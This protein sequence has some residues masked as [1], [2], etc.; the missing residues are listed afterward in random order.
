MKTFCA[1]TLLA[2]SVWGA[3]TPALAQS[4][5]VDRR[6]IMTF[7]NKVELPGVTLDAGRYIF[8]LADPTSGRKVIQVL[9]ADDEKKVYGMFLSIP[10]DMDEAPDRATVRFM[11]NAAGTPAPIRAFWWAGT[12]TG[13]EFIYP[14]EQAMRIARAAAQPVLTTATNTTRVDQTNSDDLARISSAGQVTPGSGSAPAP[15]AQNSANRTMP[16]AS[17]S[18]AA[19]Q[20]TSG[21]SRAPE[22]TLARAEPRT[23][24]PATASG[25]PTMLAWG[26]TLFAAA[27]MLRVWRAFRH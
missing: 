13:S 26:A 15:V 25:A 6:T 11:E 5:P 14:R 21:T 22:S 18:P 4:G 19:T 9:G 12:R 24:L 2:C 16:P 3:A 17:A 1:I 8:R 27:A 7:S 20:G 10:L 23:A